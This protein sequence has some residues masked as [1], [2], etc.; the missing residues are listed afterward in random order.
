ME[1]SVFR[2]LQQHMDQFPVGFPATESGVDIRI[3]KYFFTEREAELAL[4][5]TIIPQSVNQIYRRVKNLGYTK[6]HLKYVLDK[7]VDN[8]TISR[9]MWT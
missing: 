2:K 5:L 8:R 6:T 9:M 7:M 1:V 3:L 4:H